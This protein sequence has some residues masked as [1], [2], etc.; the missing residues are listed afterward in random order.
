MQ[1]TSVTV[2][3]TGTVQQEPTQGVIYVY[4]NGTGLTENIANDNLSLTL[5]IL[6][7]SMLKYVGGNL[8]NINTQ[9]YYINKI[10][11]SS[12][13]QAVE[14]LELT[15]ANI[16]NMSAAL[17]TLAKINNTYVSGVYAQLSPIQITQM[18]NQALS[19]AISNA[20]SQAEILENN[21][22]L[23]VENITVGQARFPVFLA[24]DASSI[25]SGAPNKQL[26]YYGEQGLT[27]SVTVTFLNN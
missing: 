17:S 3:A 6:N 18:R 15:I 1:V 24:S 9:S 11:N 14:Y 22:S 26:F 25:Y 19:Q 13:Y 8:S 2:T 27:E 5:E 16:K 23:K 4:I 20:T 21:A 7:T 12:T 10:K